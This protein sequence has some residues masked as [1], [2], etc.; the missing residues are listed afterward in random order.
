MPKLSN[1]HVPSYRLHKQSGQAIV[2]LSGRD[3]L[4]GRHG[5]PES[6]EKYSRVVAEWLA[7]GRQLPAEQHEITTA[8]VV[9]AFRKHARVYYRHADGTLS[10]EVDNLDA[11]VRPLLKLY[12]RYAAAEFG[13][14]K[15]QAVRNEMIAQG[16]C[17]TEI[18]KRMSRVKSV[19]KWAVSN[20]LVPA[21]VY[22]GLLSVAG[23]RL[24]RCQA[25]ESE[26][27][28]PVP[29]E[30]VDAVLPHVSP[31]VAAMIRLQLL[32]GM[33][34]GE[35]VVIRGCDIDMSENVWVYTLASHKTAHHGHERHVPLGPRAQEVIKPFLKCDLTG[36]L[37]SP[38]GAEQHR[39]AEQHA[40]RRT[41][42]SCGNRPGTNRK[43]NPSRGRG[44]HY[45][46]ESYRRAVARGCDKADAWGK[47]GRVVADAERTVP[48]WHPHQLRHTA[49][50]ELRKRFGLDAAQ[51]ML[52]HRTLTV[53]QVYAERD[54]E[55]AL[56]IAAAVG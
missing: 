15:L 12:A 34:P 47:G 45:T 28:R 52:G 32:T 56:E 46:V 17:R 30:H 39:R 5:T 1:V 55:R 16:L 8:E 48:R 19:F 13:P 23:L 51:V 9:A 22:H 36:Y 6:R 53:T 49:A 50:T 21:D 41:P 4:L 29:V 26:P 2:T 35:V 33:R 18:N 42:L 24:G 44:E 11:A 3:V 31:Q 10:R 38:S 37:F 54:T 27:V 20:E 14:L 25:R 43:L 40:K 7:A